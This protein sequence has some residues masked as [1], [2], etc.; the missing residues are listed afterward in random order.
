MKSQVAGAIQSMM[1]YDGVFA[2]ACLKRGFG[3][4]RLLFARKATGVGRRTV[5]PNLHSIIYAYSYAI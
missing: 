5:G 1:F 4:T 2:F 3:K